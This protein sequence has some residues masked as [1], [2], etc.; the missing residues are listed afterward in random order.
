[1]KPKKLRVASREQHISIL[2]LVR[3]VAVETRSLDVLWEDPR[4]G[5]RIERLIGPHVL[6]I[7]A[8][9]T[10][11]F[12]FTPEADGFCLEFIFNFQELPWR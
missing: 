4:L 10:R 8:F 5:V 11:I 1:M 3:E 6:E 12:K 7:G 9:S 2:K